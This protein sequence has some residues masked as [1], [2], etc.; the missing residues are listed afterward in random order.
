M[1][2]KIYTLLLVMLFA[3]SSLYAQQEAQ[4]SQFMFNKLAYNPGYAGSDQKICFT[5]LARQQWMGFQDPNGDNTAP[6]TFLASLDA[7]LNFSNRDNFWSR[8]GIGLLVS[9]DKLGYE[10]ATT[11]KISYSYHVNLGGGK[12]GIGAQIGFIDKKIDFA[13][14]IPIDAADPL[15]ITKTLQ[16]NF[17]TDYAF[18]LYYQMPGKY[19]LGFSSLN[20]SEPKGFNYLDSHGGTSYSYALDRAYFIMAGYEYI[21]PDNPSFELD[22]HL[23][24]KTDFKSTQYD[25]AALLRYNNKVWGGLSYRVQD[26][27]TVILGWSPIPAW[28]FGYSYDITTSSM[29]GAGKSSGSHELFVKY[30]FNIT[31]PYN[32]KSYRNTRHL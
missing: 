19:Y 25:I 11:V 1:K 21:F 22:P 30:C 31:F 13:K 23:L 3:A 5:G 2:N 28:Q 9:Q 16:S 26:A 15:L 12:L 18:G 7:C 32:P 29:G 17:F 20:L 4:F 27:I 14:F 10:K 24:V 8:S 6:Q